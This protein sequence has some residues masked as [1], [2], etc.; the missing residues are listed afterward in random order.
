MPRESVSRVG[1]Y[2]GTGS[3]MFAPIGLALAGQLVA[4]VS[5]HRRFLIAGVIVTPG[6]ETTR[7]HP[8]GRRHS[9]RHPPAQI[10]SAAKPRLRDRLHTE[11]TIGAVSATRVA[12]MML[13]N[14]HTA[15]AGRR[16][17]AGG[18]HQMHPAGN[19]QLR[20]KP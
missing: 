4:T 6:P 5:L 16:P 11:L 18:T 10:R 15:T 7:N 3:M 17:L 2:D 20:T 9:A 1:A 8:T 19:D 13:A 14:T 12:G